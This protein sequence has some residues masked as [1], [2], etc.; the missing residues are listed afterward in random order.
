MDQ[1]PCHSL[2]WAKADRTGQYHPLICHLIDVA[3]VA[4]A[5]WDNVLTDSIRRH[6]CSLLGQPPED[7]GRLLS[8]WIGLHDL[9]KA[10]P[11]FQRR[12]QSAQ[13]RLAAAGLSFPRVFARRT[14]QHGTISAQALEVMLPEETGLDSQLS[15]LVA[16][17]LGGHHGTWPIPGELQALGS[18]DVGAADW[19]AVRQETLREMKALYRPPSVDR[20]LS[21]L[22]ENCLVM[23]LSGL[24]VIAD[25]VGSMETYFPFAET[26]VCVGEYAEQARIQGERALRELGWVGWSPPRT[27]LSFENLCNVGRPRPMQQAVIELAQSLDEPAMVIIEAPTGTGKTE[28]ALYLADHWAAVRRQRGLYVAMP[29]MATSNQMYRRVRDVLGRRYPHHLVNLHLIHSQARWREDLED[30]RLETVDELE[31]GSVAAMSWFLPRKR[32]LLAPFGV[33]TVDQALLSVLQSRHFFLRLFGL[34]HKT[35]IF[36]EVHAYDTY[37]S[38]IFQRLLGWLRLLGASVVILSATLPQRT[39]REV[40]EAYLGTAGPSPQESQYPALTWAMGDR[41]GVLPL[42]G[43]EERTVELEWV[44]RKP[45]ATARLLQ[46]ELSEGGCAA[47]ICNT[48]ARSQEVYRTLREAGVV[49]GD[50]LHLFHARFPMTWRKGIEDRVLADFGKEDKR[51]GK[52]IVVATQVIEQSLD[53]DF[54]LMVSDLAPVD[55]LIQRAGRLHRHRRDT[56]PARCSVPRLFIAEPELAG[57]I[58]GFGADVY[59]YEPYVLVRSYLALQ[60]RHSLRLPADTESLIETV[61]GQEELPADVLTPELSEGLAQALQ[62]LERHQEKD[63]HKAREKLVP[64]CDTDDLVGFRSLDLEEDN[65]DLHRAFQ[66]LTRLAP[67]GVSLVCLHRT[68]EGVALEPDASGLLIDLEEQPD[69]RLTREL[70]ERTIKVSSWPVVEHFLAERPPPAWKDS[71]VLRFHRLAIFDGGVCLLEGAPYALRLTRELGLEIHRK[72]V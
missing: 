50:D 52:A 21:P 9:G 62:E 12:C 43:G 27:Q 19:V 2:L 28:A 39:R 22:E 57:G 42:E 24:C 45:G 33:G 72:E 58:P 51:P 49:A 59:V 64:A 67:P 36:D 4:G 7:S 46:S 29:T 68:A 38:T 20:V 63:V 34:S 5:L 15:K 1:R 56:R 23:L 16:R 66:A 60:G 54:D 10:S 18:R 8:F 14:C 53:L 26:P 32:T 41:S 6:F 3:Q 55:L 65:P 37:M 25:W 13:E 11:A 47:V 69:D 35:V 30:L 17:T 48:V 44:D 40:V 31:D 70:A 61:Y 71:P